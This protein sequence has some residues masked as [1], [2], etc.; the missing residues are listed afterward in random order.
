MD[1]VLDRPS[2]TPEER[3]LRADLVARASKL[4]PLLASNAQRTE[5]D[6]RVAEENITAI[7]DTWFVTGMK[8]TGS[9]TLVADDVFVPGHRYISVPKMIAGQVD[10]PYHDEA[11][12]RAAFVPG[13]AIILA[14][15]Q[16]GL[17]QAAL[18]IVLEKAPKRGIAYTF[19]DKQ[20]EA[21]GFQLAVAKA[22]SLVDSAH[23]HAYRAAADID[24]AAHHGIHPDYAARAR[25]RMDTGRA[26]V[27]AREAVRE[28]V[29]PHGASSFAESS[30]MQRHWRDS[31]V[32]SRHAVANPEISAEVYGR[33][34]LGFTSGVSPLV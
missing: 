11:L 4:V 5:D 8:G 16:L 31:E 34:L 17:A 20:T 19:Y 21:P 10:N 32:A 26:I 13:A 14:G 27:Y 12:Y 28:L 24:E 33:A 6:R 3:D 9:N 15:P 7:E 30:A 22:A 25:V 23:L 18:D 2:V 1:Y 29:S